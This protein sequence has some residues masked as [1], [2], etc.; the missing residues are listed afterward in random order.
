MKYTITIK[1]S[2]EDKCYL[3]YL[4]E[5]TDVMQPVTHGESY[6]EAVLAATEVL[7]MLVESA[8]KEGKK[9]PEPETI[10]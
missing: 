2:E 10:I 3:V 8:I 5:F 7:E 1:W 9:L 4:P 6:S